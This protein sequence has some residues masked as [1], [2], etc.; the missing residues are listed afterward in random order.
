MMRSIAPMTHAEFNALVVAQ[1]EWIADH[2][3][4]WRTGFQLGS[5]RYGQPVL[6]GEV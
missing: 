3:P 6:D 1:P 2:R 5:H 4:L